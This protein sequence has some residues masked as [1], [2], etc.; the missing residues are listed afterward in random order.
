MIKEK[1]PGIIGGFLVFLII[2]YV[3]IYLNSDFDQQL[4]QE[5]DRGVPAEKLFPQIEKETANLRLR[6]KNRFESYV[7]DRKDW[8]SGNLASESDYNSYKLSYEKA[9]EYISE[10]D[11]VRKQFVKREI[12]KEQFLLEIEPLKDVYK[13]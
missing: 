11:K 6:A 7:M 3:I 5:V 10:Y 2:L 13:L 12:S 8:G 1:W 9:L 4:I